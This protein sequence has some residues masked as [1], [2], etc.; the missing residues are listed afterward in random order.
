[1]FLKVRKRKLNSIPCTG[2]KSLDGRERG[3]QGTD[4]DE[5]PGAPL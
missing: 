3:P 4:L 5:N 2:L 1:M